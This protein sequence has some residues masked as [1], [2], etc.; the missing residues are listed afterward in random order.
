MA[1]LSK[2]DFRF[3]IKI[4]SLDA[5]TGGDDS[6]IEELAEEAVTEMKCYLSPRYNVEELF[7]TSGEGRNKT[8]TMYCRD[9]A[10]YHIFSIYNFRVIP[11]IRETRY[12]NALLW[13]Q[14]VAHQKIAPDGFPLNNN[15][16]VKTGSNDKRENH[17]L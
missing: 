17:Q 8:L 14:S 6:L 4:A 5:L 10:L 12:K 15:S 7:A 3:S 16:F 13:L 1:F 2:E 11:S 9:L